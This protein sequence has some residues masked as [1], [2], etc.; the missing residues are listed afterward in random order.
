MTVSACSVSTCIGKETPYRS[1]I[2]TALYPFDGNTNDLGGYATGTAF[3]GI[4]YTP[5]GYVSQSTSTLIPASMQYIQ[6]PNIN[7]AQQSFTIQTWLFTPAA[8]TAPSDYAI[9]GQCDG[10]SMCLS[11]SLRNGRITFSFDSMNSASTPLT[12]E[13]LITST[14]SWVHVT[15]AYDATLFQQ[16]IYVNGEIDAVSHGIVSSYQGISSSSITTIGR[17]LSYAYPVSYYSG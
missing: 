9:F 2:V 7:F 5:Q 1:S 14:L 6:I 8:I 4:T 10:N 16:Q 13:S 12:G 3:G 17:S 15:A 11:L